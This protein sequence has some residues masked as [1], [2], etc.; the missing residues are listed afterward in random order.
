MKRVLVMIAM[1][2]VAGATLSVPGAPAAGAAGFKVTTDKGR[3]VGHVA[4]GPVPSATDRIGVV[5][6]LKAFRGAVYSR[7]SSSGHVGWPVSD[8]TS[9]VAW[10]QKAGAG[11]FLVKKVP[12]AAASGRVVRSSTGRWIAQK[13]SAGRWVTVGRVHKGCRGQWAAGAT[14]LLLWNR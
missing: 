8:G 14:R 4:P 10:V 5:H 7:Q 3:T 11:R 9:Y 2:L 1:L 13:K 12:W 6:D